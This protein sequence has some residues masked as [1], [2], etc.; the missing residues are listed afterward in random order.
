MSF[1]PVR[2]LWPSIYS[3]DPYTIK[4][5][6]RSKEIVKIIHVT[7]VAQTVILQSYEILFVHK[8]NKI[9]TLFNNSGL[10]IHEGEQLMTDPFSSFTQNI[11]LFNEG[12]ICSVNQTNEMPILP[13]VNKK[14]TYIMIQ[15]SFHLSLSFLLLFSSWAWMW[16]G[17]SRPWSTPVYGE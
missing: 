15:S 5:Q 11:D 14:H 4:A 9:T 7:S 16:K 8:E 13:L 10:E 6:K 17:M 12:N 1:Q 3:K 2:A